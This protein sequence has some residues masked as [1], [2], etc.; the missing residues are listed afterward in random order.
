MQFWGL[1]FEFLDGNLL[2]SQYLSL[3]MCIYIYFFIFTPSITRKGK[4]GK[5][6]ESLLQSLR[7]LSIREMS[8]FHQVRNGL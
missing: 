6:S 1:L 4:N 3:C 2:E 7:K 5:N 8:P